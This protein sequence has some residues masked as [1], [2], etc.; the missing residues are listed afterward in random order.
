MLGSTSLTSPHAGGAKVT[1]CYLGVSGWIPRVQRSLKTLMPLEFKKNDNFN[2]GHFV[3]ELITYIANFKM[4]RVLV[5][6]VFRSNH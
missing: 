6:N 1:G 5:L 4:L 3:Y 2:A